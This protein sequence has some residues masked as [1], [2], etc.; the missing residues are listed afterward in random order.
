[1]E[2]HAAFRQAASHVF[3]Q[4]A[5]LQ[6]VSQASSVAEGRQKMAQGGIDAA[7]VDIPLP[8][9]GAAEIVR[10]LHGANPAI[11]V[12]VMTTLEE[13]EVHE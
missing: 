8:D 9:E 12:L 1:M 2:Y 13:H 11:P 3:D 5:D 10:D 7:I 4:E 6:V